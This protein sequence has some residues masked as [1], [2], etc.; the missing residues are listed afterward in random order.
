MAS[1]SQTILKTALPAPCASCSKPILLRHDGRLRI[2]GPSR[3]HCPG[4]GELPRA[5]PSHSDAG[6][7]LDPSVV[8]ASTSLAQFS[9]SPPQGKVLKRIPRGSRDAAS[10]TFAKSLNNVIQD[11]ENREAWSTMFSFAACCLKQPTDRGAK[12]RNL[13]TAVNEQING[14]SSASVT[15][16]ANSITAPQPTERRKA[17]STSTSPDAAAAKR[18]AA[19]LDEGDIKGA[20]R[21]LCSTDS[22]E[23]PSLASYH[24]L[25][26]K[27][28]PAP[29]DRR[30]PNTNIAFE[31][32]LV[33][34]SQVLNAIRSFPA[35][36][37]GGPDGLRPQHLKDMTEKQVGGSMLTALTH[38]VN[39][40]LAGKAPEWV[41]PY[42]FGASLLAFSKKDGGVRPIAV[43]LT[44]RRLVAKIVCRVATEQCIDKLKP[45]QLGVGVKGGAEALAHGA[46]RFL[47]NMPAD[48]LLIKLDFS[49]AFNSL[50][51]DSM[52][53]AI[54]QHMPGL[55]GYFDS[56]YGQS[57]HLQFGDYTIESAEGIQQGDPLGPL[58]FCL[59]IHPLLTEIQSEFVSG[60]LD[61][62]AIGGEASIAISD[63]KRLELAAK[64]FGLSLNYNKCEVIGLSNLTRSLWDSADLYF[65][66]TS[67]IDATLLGTPIQAGVGVDNALASK[68]ADLEVM[69]SRLSLLPAHAALFLIKNALAIP[70]LIY[71]L[72][73]APCAE[74][75]KLMLYDNMLKQSLSSLLNVEMTDAAWNQASLPVRWGGIGVRSAHRL[76]PSAFM[77]SAAGA[78]ELLSHIL[79]AWVL[80][81]QDPVVDRVKVLWNDFGGVIEP[82]GEESRMQRKW[83]EQCCRTM[84]EKL[85]MGADERT[86]ARLL[87]SC[88]SASG[89]WLNAIPSASLGLNLDDAALRIAVGLRL[90]V[91]LV[92]DHKCHCGASVDK[93]GHHGLS[94]R[95]SAG[96]QLRHSLLNDTIQRALQSAGVQSVREP[97]GLLRTDGKRPDGSTLVPWSRGRCLIWDATCPDTVAPSYV[98]RS[99][100]EAGTAA[101]TSETKKIS[102]YVAL[103][104]R[105]EFVPVAI[106]TFGTWGERGLSFIN[107]VGKRVAAVSGDNRSTAFLKQRMSLA[108]QRGNAAAV[109]GTLS[110]T[111]ADDD[112]N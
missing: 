96:R 9:P 35:G 66:E 21:L 32:I 50:R 45:R 52:R 63:V 7:T 89:A 102:K 17:K 92:L 95:R 81:V 26:S 53:E 40:I 37:S 64:T 77:A 97:P 34:S 59:T 42:L 58:L 110:S 111:A 112:T 30:K 109:L 107:E 68:I 29:E 31:P 22:M 70:K 65:K 24:S 90:G 36:S 23:K 67:L 98:T 46:R 79:P 76:A 2:H 103:S 49:N 91:P 83:D 27:H 94:C 101:T 12:R 74:S 84:A 19:K 25:T 93:L 38:F 88:A 20:I 18:A 10:E 82:M 5:L 108:I 85:K 100:D 51:R 41:R 99:A 1:S 55:L 8:S 54:E 16:L 15:L 44:L 14:F 3:A 47:D 60:Y 80:D 11:P 57:S 56:A 43:G 78:A 86:T 6:E 106:E 33:S 48:H 105:H 61:D 87:A 4:S 28:P 72:R 75:T 73:T 62:I 104:D 39:L 69:T 71:L 13:T